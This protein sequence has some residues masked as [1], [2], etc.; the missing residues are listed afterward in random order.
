[1]LRKT[2]RATATLL[3]LLIL[4]GSTAGAD[5]VVPSNAELWRMLQDQQKLIAE[6]KKEINELRGQL[7]AA[8]DAIEEV[9]GVRTTADESSEGG[10]SSYAVGPDRRRGS[11]ATGGARWWERTTIGS[12]GEMHYNWLR[13]GNNDDAEK[14]TLDFHRFVLFVG[15]EFTD[16]IRLFSELEVEHSLSGDGQPGE[17]ELEQAFVEWDILRDYTIRGG[18]FLMPVGILNETHE[19]TTF[20]GVERNPI[21][22]NIVP[23]TWWEGGIGGSSRWT[24]GLSGDLALTT[25]LKTDNFDI[26][27]GRQKVA[28]ADASHGALTGR[29]A[30]RG[31]PGLEIAATGQY[32]TNI[33]ASGEKTPASLFETHLI[34]HR[35]PF[36]LRA[37]YARWDLFSDDARASGKDKQYGYYVEP[38]FKPWNYLGGFFR[39]SEWNNSHGDESSGGNRMRQYD[40]GLNYWPIP[41]VVVKFDYQWQDAPREKSEFDG[42]NLGIGYSF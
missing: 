35:G 21:E 23:T 18:L 16:K 32:Q 26:R 4:A 41:N 17:V 8:G 5:E 9:Q 38:S 14:K 33:N 7:D 20:Y 19:P 6:Q 24:H 15:H 12:Y 37:L 11:D 10:E 27:D 39:F 25:G 2:L 22:K 42:F 36:G 40:V 34:Y 13:D 1:M 28:K 30:W 3:P 31:F 29:F